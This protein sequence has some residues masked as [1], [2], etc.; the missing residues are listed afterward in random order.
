MSNSLLYRLYSNWSSQVVVDHELHAARARIAV[1]THPVGRLRGAA[2]FARDQL[3]A[4]RRQADAEVLILGDGPVVVD[5]QR[6]ASRYRSP[7]SPT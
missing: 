5:A 6:D 2:A 1:G 3:G 4:L 7:R